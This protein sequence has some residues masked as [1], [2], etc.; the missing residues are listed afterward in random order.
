[1]TGLVGRDVLDPD[2][3]RAG[4]LGLADDQL[5][6]DV[7]EAPREVPRVSGAKRGVGETLP[8]SVCRDEVLEYRQAL[9]EGGDDRTRDHLAPRV[10]NEP[11]HTGDLANLLGVP[12]SARVAHD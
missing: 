2:A 5:L 7:D 3:A 9:P 1:M 12:P 6:G 10:G 11:L 8:R 4:A